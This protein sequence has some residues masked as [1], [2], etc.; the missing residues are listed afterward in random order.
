LAHI[1]LR[2]SDTSGKITVENVTLVDLN[3]YRVTL[4]WSLD[5]QPDSHWIEAFNDLVRVNGVMRDC[6]RSAYGRPIVTLDATIVW[7]ARIGDVKSSLAIVEKLIEN[8]NARVRGLLT[9]PART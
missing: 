2:A 3:L 6:V 8:A 4:E 7:A 1:D 9:H 5:R